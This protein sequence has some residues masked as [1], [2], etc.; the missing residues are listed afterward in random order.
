MKN[1]H[2]GVAAYYVYSLINYILL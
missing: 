1:P 2:P